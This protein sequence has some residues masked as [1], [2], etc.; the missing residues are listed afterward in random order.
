MKAKEQ[1]TRELIID[2]TKILLDETDDVE[3]ITVRQIAQRLMS[4]LD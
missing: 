1:I 4:E 3:K 2:T